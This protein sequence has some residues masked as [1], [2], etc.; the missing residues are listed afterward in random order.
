[1]PSIYFTMYSTEQRLI[2]SSLQRGLEQE[3]ANYPTPQQFLDKKRINTFSTNGGYLFF[4]VW[5]SLKCTEESLASIGIIDDKWKYI[6][7]C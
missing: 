1:M 5:T 2:Q 4:L 6:K 3:K 7:V